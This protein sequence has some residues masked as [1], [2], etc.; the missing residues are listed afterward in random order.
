MI[1]VTGAAGK[2]GKAAIKALAAKGAPVRALV[3]NPNHAGMLMALGASEVSLGGFDDARALA[4]ANAIEETLRGLY[5]GGKDALQ[6]AGKET[7][8]ALDAVKRLDSANYRPA[9]GAIYPPTMP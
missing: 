4:R 7:M 5:P 9:P 1:L 3:R 8:D 2:T 6:G